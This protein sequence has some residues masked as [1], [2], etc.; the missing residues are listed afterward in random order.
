MSNL[1]ASN[2]HVAIIMD[3]NGRWANARG[4]P[5]VAGHR[6]GAD[7]VRR[8]VTGGVIA[9]SA[10]RDAPQSPSAEGQDGGR[11]LR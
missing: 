9:R 5:R 6:T 11:L 8:T 7:A 4:L 3:G 1:G 10:C 2:L